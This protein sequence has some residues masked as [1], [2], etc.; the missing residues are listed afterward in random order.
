MPN[1]E[2]QN[3]QPAMCCKNCHNSSLDF[4]TGNRVCRIF[5]FS[6]AEIKVQEFVVEDAMVCCKFQWVFTIEELY[7]ETESGLIYG[8]S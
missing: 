5:D 4:E 1:P 7:G 8:I 6:N 3:Y 2:Y